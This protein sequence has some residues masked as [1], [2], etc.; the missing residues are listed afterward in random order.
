MCRGP[1]KECPSEITQRVVLSFVS[2]VFDPMGIF[3]PF[4]MSMRML[5][6]S[7][8]IHHGQSCDERLNEEDK[9]IFMDWINEMQMIRETSLPRY[10]SAFPQNVQLHIFCD[11]SLEAMCIVAFFRAKT[12]AGNEVLF[13]LGK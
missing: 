9:Q 8:W 11:A 2:S 5:L 6:K 7:I 10:F 4:T 1:N 12:D 3:A 13:V